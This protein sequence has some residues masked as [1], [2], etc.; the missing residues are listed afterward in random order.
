MNLHMM[1]PTSLVYWKIRSSEMPQFHSH[2]H[3]IEDKKSA[4]NERHLYTC[5]ADLQTR[6]YFSIQPSNIME[7]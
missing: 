1:R 7:N 2:I 6:N 3:K 4:Y 5:E